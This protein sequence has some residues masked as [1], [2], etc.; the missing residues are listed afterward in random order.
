M[1]FKSQLNLLIFPSILIP[2]VFVLTVTFITIAHKIGDMEYNLLNNNV[3]HILSRCEIEYDVIKALGMENVDYYRNATIQQVLFDIGHMF[4][5][6]STVAILDLKTS[7]IVF[8]SGIEKD[9]FIKNPDSI[10]NIVKRKRGQQEYYLKTHQGKHITVM[11]SFAVDDKWNWL[12]ICY[13]EKKD[14][15]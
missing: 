2:V 13:A 4:T 12:I 15:F 3:T 7:E 14:C 9:L 6:N 11:A 1:K 8:S 10:G 5:S